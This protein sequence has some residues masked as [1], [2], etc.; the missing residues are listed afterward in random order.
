[1]KNFVLG[2]AFAALSGVAIAQTTVVDAEI[3]ENLQTLIQANG[4]DCVEVVNVQPVGAAG[5][6]ITCIRV[7]GGDATNVY[8]FSVTA[9]GLSVT[10]R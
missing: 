6:E 5:A 10:Q 2:I 9:D 1:M 7:A 4:F 3:A 8:D